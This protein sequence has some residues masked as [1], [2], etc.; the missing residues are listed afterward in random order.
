MLPDSIF[1]MHPKDA[2]RILA[3]FHDIQLPT[4]AP[5]TW[6]FAMRMK[7]MKWIEQI[8]ATL[9]KEK[10]SELIKTYESILF[11]LMKMLVYGS[12]GILVNAEDED[13]PIPEAPIICPVSVRGFD[14]G[15]GTWLPPHQVDPVNVASNDDVLVHWFAESSLVRL[16]QFRKFQIL[17]GCGN[18]VGEPGY[19]VAR[20]W[21]AQYGHCETIALSSFLS[22]HNVK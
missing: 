9:S 22:M 4:K 1:L 10:H 15:L 3:W 12:G 19:E 2:V 8:L 11:W 7:P 5:G 6:K 17:T 21:V 18:W 20:R 16:E 13:T 14:Q